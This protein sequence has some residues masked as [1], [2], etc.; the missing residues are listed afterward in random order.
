MPK[1]GATPDYAFERFATQIMYTFTGHQKAL[2]LLMAGLGEEGVLIANGGV[3][4]HT[5]GFMMETF[6]PNGGNIGIIQAA[7]RQ[8]LVNQVHCNMY[9]ILGRSWPFLPTP[10]PSSPTHAA[11]VCQLHSRPH[12][13]S[14]IHIHVHTHGPCTAPR[15]VQCAHGCRTVAAH[16]PAQPREMV[17]CCYC[18]FCNTWF[19]M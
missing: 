1:Q 10:P 9:A 2:D 8:G 15:H 18:C 3:N 14:R 13:L 17:F 4:N 16:V 7:A 6:M 11:A 5:N 12:P 19:P